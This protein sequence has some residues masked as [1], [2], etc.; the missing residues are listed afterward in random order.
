M[1]TSMAAAPTFEVALNLLDGLF[2]EQQHQSAWIE[3]LAMPTV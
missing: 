2:A 3:A 1:G